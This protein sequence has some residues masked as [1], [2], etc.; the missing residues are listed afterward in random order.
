MLMKSMK[1]LG[2]EHRLVYAHPPWHHRYSSLFADTGVRGLCAASTLRKAS[3]KPL[4]WNL[5][6]E[7]QEEEASVIKPSSEHHHEKLLHV[8]LAC[9]GCTNTFKERWNP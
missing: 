1:L 3:Q 9:V 4:K 6:T 7:M 8:P 2:T 5:E